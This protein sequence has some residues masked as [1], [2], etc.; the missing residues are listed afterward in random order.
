MQAVIIIIIYKQYIYTLYGVCSY[1]KS[2]INVAMN[3]PRHEMHPQEQD[4]INEFERK[5]SFP[6]VACIIS[7]FFSFSLAIT[8]SRCM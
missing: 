1:I 7:P 2:T 3:L 8:H 5:R 6:A 4:R